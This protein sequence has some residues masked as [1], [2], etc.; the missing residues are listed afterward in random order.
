MILQNIARAIR[1]QNYYAVAME[2]IIVLA[3]VVI[4]FQVN[5]WNE[6]RHEAVR[7]AELLERI[8]EE[9]RTFETVLTRS[10]RIHVEY[11]QATENV[12]HAIRQDAVATTDRQQ[13]MEWLGLLRHV[14]RP[15][16]RSAVYA[17]M[18]SSGELSL[19]P[20]ELRTELSR[21]DQQIE[22][23]EYLWPEAASHLT[24]AS[25]LWDAVEYTS[26]NDPR[27]V[28]GFD[29]ERVP[30]AESELEALVIY[31]GALRFTI[32]ATLESARDILTMVEDGGGGD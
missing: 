26:L 28:T 20:A 8:E 27:R 5:G 11:E 24:S 30:L 16:T 12:I 22:R 25:A 6:R 2:F 13:M 9:F 15:P 29:P 18:I 17:E 10:E 4:G 1:E 14:G 21:F 7:A 3:G 31:Q 23:N 32:T 19:L